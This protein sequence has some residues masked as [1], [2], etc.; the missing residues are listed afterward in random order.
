M[1]IIIKVVIRKNIFVHQILFPSSCDNDTH[2]SVIISCVKCY[3]VIL[4]SDVNKCTRAFIRHSWMVPSRTHLHANSLNRFCIFI[5]NLQWSGFSILS[6]CTWWVSK[7]V[8]KYQVSL[9]WLTILVIFIIMYNSVR[10]INNYILS[11]ESYI[12]HPSWPTKFALG[13]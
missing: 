1:L 5:W 2:S 9:V 13:Y 7:L 8:T 12:I 3:I 4:L 6:I 10:Y 11:T